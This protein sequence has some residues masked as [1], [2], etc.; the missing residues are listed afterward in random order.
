VNKNIVLIGPM[1][2]GKTSVGRRLSCVLHKDFFDTD[3]EIVSRTGVSIEH[4]FDIEGEE[5]FRK[6][7]TKVLADLAQIPNLVIATGGGIVVR[8]E[9]LDI[10]KSTIVVYLTAD[11]DVLVDRCSKS[12]ARPLINEAKDKKQ[13]ITDIFN[14]RKNLYKQAADIIIDVSGKR[15]YS[16]IN[17]IKEYIQSKENESRNI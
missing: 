16:I 14:A 10:L 3:F 15:L 1:G 4:I 2:S 13:T 8:E 5:G 9:N 6:R 11:I 17:E 12:K 7:E